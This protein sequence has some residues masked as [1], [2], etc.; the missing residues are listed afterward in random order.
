MSR[1]GKP[2]VVPLG[3]PIDPL[4]GLET[5]IHSPDSVRSLCEAAIRVPTSAGATQNIVQARSLK[6]LNIIW[7]IDPSN[8]IA[9]GDPSQGFDGPTNF[10]LS[11][12]A[13][14]RR[15]AEACRTWQLVTGPRPRTLT[16][17]LLVIQLTGFS[18]SNRW[19]SVYE[20]TSGSRCIRAPCNICVFSG[21]SGIFDWFAE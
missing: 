15:Q 18:I 11:T 1:S 17:V 7:A 9:C 14:V 2:R 10:S 19:R 5:T 8:E 16:V 12:V 4:I 13:R 6:V 3:E 21:G 20:V